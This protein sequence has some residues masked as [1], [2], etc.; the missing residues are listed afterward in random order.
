[1]TWLLII[2]YLNKK[3]KKIEAK[4]N[5]PILRSR[6]ETSRNYAYLAP[7]PY[8]PLLHTFQT[9]PNQT[10][11]QSHINYFFHIDILCLVLWKQAANTR[12]CITCLVQSQATMAVEL[13]RSEG[14]WCWWRRMCWISMTSTLLFSIACMSCWG[15]RFLCNSLV[16]WMLILVSSIFSLASCDSHPLMFITFY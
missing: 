3:E 16:L 9:K 7:S 14:L 5:V 2:S 12:C 10:T 15:K 6:A 11:F 4:R 8:I 1:M 13:N